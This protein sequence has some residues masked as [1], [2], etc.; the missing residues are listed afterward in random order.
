MRSLKTFCLAALAL[1]AVQATN[2]HSGLCANGSSCEGTPADP[3]RAEMH[4]SRFFSA[5]Q[6]EAT[7]NGQAARRRADMSDQEF[8]SFS[9]V[10]AIVCTVNGKQT[11]ATAF[12]VGAFDIGVTVAHAFTRNGEWT[13]P[14]DCVYTTTDSVGQIRERI[15]VSYIKA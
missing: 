6:M 11:T 13:P 1:S 8:F 3:G 4:Q 7:S 2:A 15:A 12:L 14:D 10:G 5:L 9:G